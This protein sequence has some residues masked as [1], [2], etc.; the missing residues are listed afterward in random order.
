MPD[1]LTPTDRGLYC[2]LGDFYVDPWK[3][4]DR[5][6]VTHAH[7]DHASIGS[8]RYLTSAAGVNVLRVRLGDEAKIEGVAYGETVTIGETRV[9]L[10][11]AGHIL[12][13]SQVRI[14]H[15]GQVCVVSGD[16]KTMADDTCEAF[17]PLR[18]HTFVTESTFGLPIY[19]WEPADEVFRDINA[20]WMTNQEQGRTSLIYAY[21]LGKAQRV[22]AGLDAANGPILV[23]G[24]IDRFLP[25]Y[26]AGGVRLPITERANENN[27]KA[28]RGRAMVITP[29][30]AAGTPWLRK[31]G[32]LSTA[33]ASGW[34]QIRGPR[35]RRAVDRGFA[36]SDHADWNG[37][38]GAI[39]ATGAE[40]IWVTHGYSPVMVRWLT[41]RGKQA[42]VIPTRYEGEQLDEPDATSD[43]E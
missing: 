20:W 31:F 15:G 42:R 23:H 36:L 13:S 10:H 27:A 19:R 6:V 2:A 3:P 24:A 16:Y 26:E 40:Q 1:L 9:S 7:S 39:E 12:G 28:S 32:P 41:E 30:S 38:L 35:R 21:S 37:L 11:P 8:Q 29:P 14:E 25:A 43:S 34:M 18:C 22:L 33:I 5:A 17:D 4:V